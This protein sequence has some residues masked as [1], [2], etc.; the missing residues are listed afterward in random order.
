MRSIGAMVAHRT[1]NPL[2]PSSSLGCSTKLTSEEEKMPYG[3]YTKQEFYRDVLSAW[4]DPKNETHS[5]VVQSLLKGKYSWNSLKSH[6]QSQYSF[7]P[8]PK[9]HPSFG[10][11]RITPKGVY[12]DDFAYGYGGRWVPAM[13][14]KVSG[15][16]QAMRKRSIHLSPK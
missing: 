2:V 1:F 6:Y 16:V 15:A 13:I 12:D 5:D 9:D 4:N 14:Q 10:I 8:F 7:K 11:P 3:P